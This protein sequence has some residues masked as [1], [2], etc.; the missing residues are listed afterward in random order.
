MSTM[1]TERPKYLASHYSNDDNYI[2]RKLLRKLRKFDRCMKMKNICN[3][4]GI[5]LN[6]LLVKMHI[7]TE[8]YGSWTNHFG[9]TAKQQ[10]S[11]RFELENAG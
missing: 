10:D 1:E 5:L 8:I 7:S 6:T 4:T 3:L 11:K 2:H 9:I